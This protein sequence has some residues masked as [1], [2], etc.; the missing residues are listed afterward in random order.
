MPRFL[1]VHTMQPDALARFRALPKE[2]R[3][4]VDPIGLPLRVE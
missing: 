2:E 1:A 4:R 3:E